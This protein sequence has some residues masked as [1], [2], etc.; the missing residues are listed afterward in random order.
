MLKTNLNKME[1][2]ILFSEEQKFKQWWLWVILLGINS[3]FIFG[4]YQQIICGKPFGDKPTSNT[5]LLIVSGGM[6]LLTILFLNF[7][8]QTIIK[9][10][11]IYVR[12]FPIHQ[13]YRKYTWDKLIKIYVRKYNAITE[14][15]GWGI[16]LG[17][18]GKGNALNVSGNNGLQLEIFKKTNLL[19]GTNKPEE[20]EAVLNKLGQLKP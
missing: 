8:L 14:Y 12:F 9:E 11:G 15:G 10:D 18:F 16:R 4:I 7:K 6:L 2:K 19:I 5:G 1:S 13:A 20:L 3:I 17:I